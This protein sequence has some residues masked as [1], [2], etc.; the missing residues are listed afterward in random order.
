MSRRPSFRRDAQLKEEIRKLN[1]NVQN[2]QSRI[3]MKTGLESEGFDT[4]RYS[5]F[6]SR[7]EI[8]RYKKHMETF[9]DRNANFGVMNDQGVMLEYSDVRELD[10]RIKKVNKEK[11]KQWDAIKDL[12]FTHKG[13][14]TNLTVAQQ[15]N[16]DVGM[17]DSRY[18]EFRGLT[19]N[20]HTFTSSGQLK[21][22]LDRME[23]L[24]EQQNFMEKKNQLARD[25][26]L[27]GMRNEGLNAVG[28]GAQIY[29][30]IMEMGNDE[31][32]RMFYTEN[33]ASISFLYDKVSREARVTE[34]ETIWLKALNKQK[35]E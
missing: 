17:G 20:P 12:P 14:P 24:Y 33:N 11:R 31:F 3:R 5:E 13:K 23:E 10:K 2:K 29:D 35:G 6:K 34:L 22:R 1:R 32:I 21:K 26:Y 8:E 18:S 16:P 15:A 30:R 27:Q 9:L 4:I 28:K 25:N 19:F 7:R